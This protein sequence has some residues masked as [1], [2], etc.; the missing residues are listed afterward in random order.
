MQ[1]KKNYYTVM[2][3]PEG[4]AKTF[5]MHIHKNVV[6]SLIAFLCIFLVGFVLLVV[7]SGEIAAK[8][9]LVSAL[10]S[11]NKQLKEDNRKMTY[12][13]EKMDRIDQLGRY[14]QRIATAE[15]VGTK[16]GRPSFGSLPR[17]D[18]TAFSKDNNDDFL[19]K[20]Q[21]TPKANVNELQKRGEA[22]EVYLAALPNIQPVVDGW[23]TRRFVVVASDTEQA[24]NGIDYAATLG[25]L[26]RATA[27]GVVEDVGNDK[28]FGLILTIKH[29]YGF[30]TKYGHCSQILVAK[31]DHVERGQT[32]ALVGNT[33][34]SSAPHLHYEVLKDGKNI[35]PT[36]YI[37]NTAGK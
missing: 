12:I 26:I 11:E 19:N 8:L 36:R 10:S 27:Q 31:G 20:I 15:G 5:S 9:Q 16:P 18:D 7:K 13:Y 33:G 1:N 30:S 17:S 22:A 35:D 29:G 23:I 3:I 6:Y 28:Y 24:H 21:T 37:Y 32:I 34:R 4:N 25:T 14:L 2:F